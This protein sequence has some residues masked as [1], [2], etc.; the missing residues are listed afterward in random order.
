MTQVTPSTVSQSISEFYDCEYKA[1]NISYTSEESI[2]NEFS[3]FQIKVVLFSTNPA[4]SPLLKNF[5]A[6]ALS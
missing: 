5:R 6:I 3:Y 4:R 2:F 1:E